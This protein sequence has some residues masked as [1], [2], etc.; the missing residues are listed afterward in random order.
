VLKRQPKPPDA[1]GEGTSEP[2]PSE[3]FCR[4]L[5]S[6]VESDTCASGGRIGPASG[7]NRALLSA[8]PRVERLS[9]DIGE[10]EKLRTQQILARYLPAPPAVIFDVGGGAGVHA[11]P[12]AEKG[13]Q[14]HLVDP[15]ELHLE[16]VRSREMESGVRLASIRP[17]DARH[18]QA[19][20]ET[21]DAFLLLG[22]LYHLVERTDRLEALR[23]ARRILRP[24]AVLFA[25]A[26]S[27]FASLV[28]GVHTAFFADPAFRDIIETDLLS[29][30]H[31]NP[32]KDPMY[33]TTAFFHRPEELERE[34]GEAGFGQVR[35]FGIEGP[36]WSSAQFGEVWSDPSQRERLMK[37]LSLIEEEP[38]I[39]GASAH[40]L[41]VA[42][43]T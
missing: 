14:L 43:R 12:L 15:V 17:G 33:F 7:R 42:L 22:P 11:F 13:Y 19:D 16:Q 1:V 26:I 18:L 36:A 34:L 40:L 10:L 3:F 37:F 4:L 31:R 8:W 41:A 24:G 2:A 23:E 28:G 20:D 29:G 30:Q 35:V 38:S 9:S 21:A 5:W 25:S 27:R 6:R 39:L 32:T